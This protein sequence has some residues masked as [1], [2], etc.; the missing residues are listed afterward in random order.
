MEGIRS[1]PLLISGLRRESSSKTSEIEIDQDD[2]STISP[3]NDLIS[4]LIFELLM[5]IKQ[6]QKSLKINLL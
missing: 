5:E 3:P 6:L 4:N 2:K 1:G